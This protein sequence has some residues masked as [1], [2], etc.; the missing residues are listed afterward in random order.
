MATTNEAASVATRRARKACTQCR[1]Q[2]ARC[3]IDIHQPCSRCSK[4]KAECIISDHFEREHKRRKLYQLQNETDLLRQR[5][6]STTADES[7]K[8]TPG[9]NVPQT[10]P[11]FGEQ[12]V[13]SEQQR[14][15]HGVPVVESFLSSSLST[16]TSPH[17]TKSQTLSRPI[18]GS[19]V[20]E[21]HTIDEL[22]QLFF[23]KYADILPILDPSKTPNQ[24]YNESE[25]LFWTVIGTASRKYAPNTA[26]L[27]TTRTKV[28][29]LALSS[30]NS[31]TSKKTIEAL[32]ILLTWPFPRNQRAL[33]HTFMLD[34]LMF[35]LAVQ[36]GLHAFDSPQEYSRDELR[37]SQHEID[38]QAQLW[39]H[40]LMTHQSIF[41]IKGAPSVAFEDITLDPGAR[42]RVM[43]SLPPDLKAHFQITDTMTRCCTALGKIGL[44]RMTSEQEASLD[45]LISAFHT[46]LQAIEMPEAPTLMTT[47][48][49]MVAELGTMSFYLYRDPQRLSSHV[50][51]FAK[52]CTKALAIVDTVEDA[53]RSGKVDVPA[54][55]FWVEFGLIGAAC[56]LLRL[57]KSPA[58]KDA[59]YEEQARLGAQKASQLSKEVSIDQTDVPWR[60]GIIVSQLLTSKKAFI[61]PDT[62][63][64][65]LKP[66]SVPLRAKSRL[67]VSHVLDTGA[68]WREE[69]GG[70]NGMFPY[71]TGSFRSNQPV[72]T[73]PG[74]QPNGHTLEGG[75]L[76]HSQVN[77]DND[78]SADD[79]MLY[80]NYLQDDF[81]TDLW[82]SWP[83]I[84]SWGVPGLS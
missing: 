19:V 64:D 59:S 53:L 79:T 11:D 43:H 24:Y 80:S 28:V 81:F 2:K 62:L 20:L 57:A 22:F 30:A 51:I 31:N 23:S 36:G 39:A 1:Q 16:S 83:E 32:L 5:L 47:L 63:E 33:D 55:P 68:W 42:Q 58:F 60:S 78:L 25:F 6:S 48:K 18:D 76:D 65:G 84:D 40:C 44:R 14:C 49:L 9:R 35:Q 29:N 67:A 37:I 7:E 73:G 8:G 52:L 17:G 10:S 3:D 12:S 69:F 70:M 41:M 21:A 74:Q 71:P 54:I 45:I 38:R 56:I 61:Y 13:S 4:I 75:L 46:E 50:P 82:G 26:L 34:G 15:I 77:V 27:R 72:R 66:Q